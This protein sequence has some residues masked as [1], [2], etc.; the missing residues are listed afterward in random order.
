MHEREN[1]ARAAEEREIQQAYGIH[2]DT[3][4]QNPDSQTNQQQQSLGEEDDEL[5]PLLTIDEHG[6]IVEQNQ[7]QQEENPQSATGETE[8]TKVFFK[9]WPLDARIQ[10][11]GPQNRILH[12]KHS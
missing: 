9:C 8:Q 2:V 7:G 1:R 6:N 10:K 4:E 11:I 12:K 5:P 3:Y